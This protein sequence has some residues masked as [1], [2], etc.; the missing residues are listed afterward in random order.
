MDLMHLKDIMLIA[1]AGC[2]AKWIGS[3]LSHLVQSVDQLNITRS[4]VL[5]KLESHHE[6]LMEHQEKLFTIENDCKIFHNKYIGVQ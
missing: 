5:T 2:I 1:L 6:K 4:S 3:Q